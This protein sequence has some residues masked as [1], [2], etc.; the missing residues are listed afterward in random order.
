MQQVVHINRLEIN[1]IEFDMED[2]EIP[3]SP[4]QEHSF[5]L[6]II[7]Y[8]TPTH[9]HVSVSESIKQNITILE[10]NPY[11]TYEEYIPIVVRIPFDGK[12]IYEGNLHITVSHGAKKASFAMIIGQSSLCENINRPL[13]IDEELII[14]PANKRKKVNSLKDSIL[15]I[16]HNGLKLDYDTLFAKLVMGII[17]L[18]ILVLIVSMI[19]KNS[20][21]LE[22]FYPALLLSMLFTALSVVAL[23]KLINFK[24]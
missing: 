18:F 13:E 6:V 9:V 14:S 20:S 8:S 12:N 2:L 21:P 17:G 5:E 7:N 3:I 23:T 4:G 24:K 10:D 1:S 19:T 16:S 15:G 11:V 22:S